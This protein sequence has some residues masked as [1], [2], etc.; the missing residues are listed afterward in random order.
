MELTGIES[1]KEGVR[2]RQESR[3]TSQ[4]PD[5]LRYA[6]LETLLN[7]QEGGVS[8]IQR[9]ELVYYNHTPEALEDELTFLLS[10]KTE[11]DVI[12]DEDGHWHIHV[13]HPYQNQ[14]EGLIYKINTYS[15]LPVFV[16]RPN[17]IPL[18]LAKA[19]EGLGKIAM[20]RVIT[21]AVQR[22][23]ESV[24]PTYYHTNGIHGKVKWRV[25][26]RLKNVKAQISI[27]RFIRRK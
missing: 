2:C 12:L 23:Y 11:C 19:L 26:T 14:A 6:I 9:V 20:K 10:S 24:N 3:E 8:W 1:L 25:R 18:D 21:I 16:I 13:F 4:A 27:R 7:S 15:P 17:D 22:L 5:A